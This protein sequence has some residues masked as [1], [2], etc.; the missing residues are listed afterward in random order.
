MK[1]KHISSIIDFDKKKL[2]P[3]LKYNP[4]FIWKVR[5]KIKQLKK[6]SSPLGGVVALRSTASIVLQF[7]KKDKGSN[8]ALGIFFSFNVEISAN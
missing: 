7:G 8:T 6:V 5:S 3:F 4:Y 1:L 2:L